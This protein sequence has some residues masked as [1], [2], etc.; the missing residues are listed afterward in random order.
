MRRLNPGLPR[1]VPNAITCNLMRAEG[2]LTQRGG[3]VKMEQKVE[4][5]GFGGWRDEATSQQMPAATSSWKR[6]GMDFVL[7]PPE[8]QTP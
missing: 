8:E 5:A 1:H 3:D 4:D 6:K 7:E 2:N